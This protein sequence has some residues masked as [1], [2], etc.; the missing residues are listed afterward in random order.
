[1][2]QE[3]RGEHAGAVDAAGLEG[4]H[5]DTRLQS[6]WEQ[7]NVLGG[8]PAL[9]LH[10]GCT[11]QGQALLLVSEPKTHLLLYSCVPISLLQQ[12]E[13]VFAKLWLPRPMVGALCL[14][15]G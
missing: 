9:R 3:G 5:A 13:H 4:F 2:R 11:A 8:R 1:M 12:W 14:L 15:A 6:V 10:S 7:A